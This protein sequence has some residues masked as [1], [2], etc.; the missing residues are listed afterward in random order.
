[1]TDLSQS[2]IRLYDLVAKHSDISKKQFSALIS[3]I[4][5]PANLQSFYLVLEE[6][7]ETLEVVSEIC[8][9]CGYDDFKATNIEPSL[10]VSKILLQHKA[11]VEEMPLLNRLLPAQRL[12]PEDDLKGIFETYP[13]YTILAHSIKEPPA[14]NQKYLH[15]KAQALLA[16]NIISANNP[17]QLGKLLTAYRG[18]RYLSHIKYQSQLELVPLEPTTPEIFLETTNAGKKNTRL[19]AARSLIEHSLDG[20]KKRTRSNINKTITTRKKTSPSNS[21]ETRNRVEHWTGAEISIRSS[22]SKEEAKTFEELGGKSTEFQYPKDDVPVLASAERTYNRTT[23]RELAFIAKQTSNKIAMRNQFSPFAWH[24]LNQHD[25]ATLLDF[26]ARDTPEPDLNIQQLSS[27]KTILN[28]MFW[29]GCSF[30]RALAL[31]ISAERYPSFN[32]SE[33]IYGIGGK[34]PYIRLFTPGPALQE[35]SKERRYKQA[36]PVK[37]TVNIPLCDMA[38][39]VIKNNLRIE[40]SSF[41]IQEVPIFPTDQIDTNSIQSDVRKTLRYLN[42]KFGTRLTATNISNHLPYHLSRCP[43]EDLP[44]AMLFFGRDDEAVTRMHYTLAPISRLEKNFIEMCSKHLEEIGHKIN[45]SASERVNDEQ[46]AIGTPWCPT[47]KAIIELARN[48]QEDVEIMRPRS[49]S[50]LKAFYSF[51]NQYTLYTAQLIA[52]ATS[53]RAIRSPTIRCEE[54]HPKT[55]FLI[56]SDKDDDRHYSTRR[57]WLPNMCFKQIENYRNHL[58]AIWDKFGTTSA[59]FFELFKKCNGTDFPLELFFIDYELLDSEPFRPG[60]TKK[61]L[62]KHYEYE[63]PQN[64]NRHFLKYQLLKRGCEQEI[65]ETFMGHWEIGQEPWSNISNLHPFTFKDRIAPHLESILEEHGW[66]AVEGFRL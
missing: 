37:Y 34:A 13:L 65:I 58:L 49:S 29:C 56:I 32:A 63:L 44:S 5:P 47:S 20:F 61:L 59:P 21:S 12:T 35:E 48:L 41:Q 18:I 26:L 52:F 42:K 51:H 22:L 24:E 43:G 3:T 57:V 14:Q 33:S 10:G 25:V 17:S 11:T 19:M 66:M 16:I 27:K 60:L 53:Y 15:L 40:F 38:A 4:M 45:F 39:R 46:S 30:E 62:N 9:L 54:I 36:H 55:G 7:Q 1:M 2:Q 64:A 23:L 50:E 6:L 31:K 8:N 28:I